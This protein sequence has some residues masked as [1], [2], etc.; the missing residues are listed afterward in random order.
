[1]P[2]PPSKKPASPAARKP[3]AKSLSTGSASVVAPVIETGEA[4]IQAAEQISATL[5]AQTVPMLT[6][7]ASVVDDGTRRSNE[8]S[9]ERE[10]LVEVQQLLTAD[11]EAAM[12]ALNRQVEDIDEAVRLIHGGIP[13]VTAADQSTGA[14]R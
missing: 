8:L 13:H 6:R 5:K 2:T 11:Y 9:R 14:E 7:A 1:M 10:R 3:R 4:A 12:G